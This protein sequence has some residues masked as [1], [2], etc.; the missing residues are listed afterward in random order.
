MGE[1]QQSAQDQSTS[2]A[3]R[4]RSRRRRK[5]ETPEGDTHTPTSQDMDTT[6]TPDPRPQAP[7]TRAPAR[8]RGKSRQSGS[9]SSPQ[10]Q[11]AA[12]QQPSSSK[13]PRQQSQQH[14]QP[15]QQSEPR[16]QI[17]T[18]R[19][20]FGGREPRVIDADMGSRGT[21]ELTPFELFCTYHLGITEENTYRRPN[22]RDVARRFRVSV[23]EMHDA[24][25]RFGLDQRALDHY[26]FDINLALLDVK[27]VPEGIDRREIARVHFDE[28]IETNEALRQ[29]IADAFNAPTGAAATQSEPNEDDDDD[30]D[31]DHDEQPD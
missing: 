27:V 24:L 30:H 8:R 26:D 3:R 16:Y 28:L 9:S 31:D 10:P 11:Q 6:S 2:G 5:S 20:K 23:D 22:A 25:R 14:H 7:D 19:E 21:L 29:L 13:K 17:K 12:P 15:K 18:P 4:R 1:E